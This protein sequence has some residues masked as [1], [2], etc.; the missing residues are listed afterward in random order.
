MKA[1]LRAV[2]RRLTDVRSP[3]TR[4][5]LVER[6]RQR[7]EAQGGTLTAHLLAVLTVAQRK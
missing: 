2:K 3:A 1:A 7:I 4:V 6:V 5:E